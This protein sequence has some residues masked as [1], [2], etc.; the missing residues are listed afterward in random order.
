M[1]TNDQILNTLYA[2]APQFVTSDTPTLNRYATLISILRPQ[3]NEDILGLNAPLAYAYLLAHMLSTTP[4]TGVADNMS[5]GELN[6]KYALSPESSILMG[7]SYGRAYV[8][9][10]KRTIFAPNVTQG[11]YLGLPYL[12]W[13]YVF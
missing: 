3:V 13:P 1:V 6:I 9:L 7:T 10:C 4:I 11:Y 8:D 2:I 5:E 12:G